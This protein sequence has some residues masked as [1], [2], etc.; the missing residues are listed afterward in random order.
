MPFPY[1]RHTT[2]SFNVYPS[3]P[4]LTCGNASQISQGKES[5]YALVCKLMCLESSSFLKWITWTMHKAQRTG[6]GSGVLLVS[7]SY[8]PV[9]LW[10]SCCFETS[11]L[12]GSQHKFMIYFLSYC[13]HTIR[14]TGECGGEVVYVFLHQL[15]WW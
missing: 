2:W 12:K 8:C 3:I 13:V 7:L 9:T 11:F 4:F 6:S 5:V 1:V 10:W 14:A 15:W